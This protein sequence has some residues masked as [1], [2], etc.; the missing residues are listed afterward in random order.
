MSDTLLIRNGRPMGGAAA[1]VL[2]ENGRIA[3]I[4][5]DLAGPGIAIE[6]AGGALV[7]PGLVE[8]Q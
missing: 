2:I 4:G 3:A 8:A 6:D 1:D 5:A 7:L